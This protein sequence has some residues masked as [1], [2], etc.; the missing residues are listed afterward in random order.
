MHDRHLK[1][2]ATPEEWN[3]ISRDFQELWNFP[4]CLGALD[5]KHVVIQAPKKSGT[6]YY[7]Y[8]GTFSIVLL[9]AVDA[10][11]RF[12]YVDVGSAGKNSDGGIFQKSSFNRAL[13]EGKLGIPPPTPIAGCEDLGD[14]NFVFVADEAFPLQSSLM[15]PFPGRNIPIQHAIFNYRLFRARRIVENAFGILCAR[16]RVFHTKICLSPVDVRQ[17]V[18]TACV[19]HNFVTPQS[20]G[21]DVESIE[22]SKNFRELRK[23]GCKSK[24]QV[25]DLRKTFAKY[26]S[27]RDILPWQEKVVNRGKFKYLR[28]FT[29][30]AFIHVWFIFIFIWYFEAGFIS[31]MYV[32]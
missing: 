32:V 9:A 6:V 11:Y 17:I 8:K 19:L 12:I 26:F 1:M 7:N 30:F 13:Q 14:L 27:E 3:N 4:H 25:L 18:K 16:W 10:H 5:G 20:N 29:K 28:G 23:Y 22:F 15:R 31:E 2:P 21:V 24:K